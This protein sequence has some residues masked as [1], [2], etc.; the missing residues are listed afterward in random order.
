MYVCEQFPPPQRTHTISHT[1]THTHT[2]TVHIHTHT[3]THTHT[4]RGVYVFCGARAFHPF[5]QNIVTVSVTDLAS[6]GLLVL[7][8]FHELGQPPHILRGPSLY[9]HSPLL[10]Q[11]GNLSLILRDFQG[12]SLCVCETERERERV[13]VCV[14]VCVCVCV[15]ERERERE[16]RPCRLSHLYSPT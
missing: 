12:G 2:H 10:L 11:G 7:D 6:V 8:L 13:C 5:N 9:L 1:H 14:F 4:P 16:R 3:H 15:R